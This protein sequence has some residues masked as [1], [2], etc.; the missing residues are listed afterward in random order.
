ML[1]IKKLLNLIWQ[2]FIYGAHLL[3]LGAG[4]I[5]L[6]VALLLNGNVSWDYPI[7]IYLIAYSGYLYNRYKEVEIDFLT[8]PERTKHLKKYIKYVPLI[9]SFVFLIIL[10]ILVYSN[11][12]SVLPLILLLFFGGLFYTIFLKKITKKIFAFKSFFAS[13][14]WT[15]PLVF[16][17]IYYSFP[18][19]FPLLIIIIIVFLKT[20][21]LVGYFDIK[22]IKID[23]KERLLTFPIVLNIN[24][25]LNFLKFSTIFWGSIIIF[26]VE[27][28]QLPVYSL[29]LLFTIPFNLYIFQE[30]QKATTPLSRLYFLAGGEFILWPIL[31]LIGKVGL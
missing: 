22:D 14:E 26:S 27:F 25:Y 16:L 30:T 7:I 29:M 12:L 19:S 3:A 15:L 4:A 8:N 6:S 13:F 9:I 24:N 17:P 28:Q 2:E 31:I 5:V 11:K 23:K 20:L 10:G 18:F 1:K 21:I